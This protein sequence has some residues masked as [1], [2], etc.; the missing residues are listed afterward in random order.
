MI[1]IPALFSFQAGNED[2]GPEP[3]HNT[4]A[5][6]PDCSGP[7]HVDV[8]PVAAVGAIYLLV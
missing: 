5:Y 4:G 8:V 2:Q 7:N 1:E 6:N 3:D